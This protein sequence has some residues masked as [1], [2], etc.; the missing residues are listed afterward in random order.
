MGC[1]RPCT[2]AFMYSKPEYMTAKDTIVTIYKEGGIFN[3]W[4][5]LIPRMT[6]IICEWLPPQ[7]LQVH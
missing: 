2:Q 5:G 6:R 1:A 4:R 7:H 3:F